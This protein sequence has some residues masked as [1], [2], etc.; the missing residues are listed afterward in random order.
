MLILLEEHHRNKILFVT[1]IGSLDS[2][3]IVCSTSLEQHEVLV[4]RRKVNG[5][6]F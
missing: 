1:R 4:I 3:R 2:C 6:R 5:K